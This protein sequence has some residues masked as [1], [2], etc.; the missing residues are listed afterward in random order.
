MA[1]FSNSTEVMNYEQQYCSKCVHL[2]GADGDGCAVMKTH[3]VHL[4]L[5]RYV[6]KTDE[7]RRLV[8]S[9]LNELIPRSKE[10]RPDN[11]LKGGEA[12]NW[13]NGGNE[14]CLMFFP[15]E[16]EGV[17]ER[18]SSGVWAIHREGHTPIMIYLG[19]GFR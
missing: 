3:R 6:E 14:R 5:L 10:P 4:D 2:G 18:Q 9:V 19:E 16:I 13:L 15:D 11:W 7:E 1:Y 8:T 17:L 12:D